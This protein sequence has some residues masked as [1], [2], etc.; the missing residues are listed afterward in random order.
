M[1]IQL[2]T[3]DRA[4]TLNKKV[5]KMERVY[6]EQECRAELKK[7]QT[8]LNI[9]N[10]LLAALEEG[11]CAFID[12]AKG[13]RF[14]IVKAGTPTTVANTGRF[15]SAEE[16]NQKADDAARA[17]YLYEKLLEVIEG[18][19]IVVCDDEANKFRIDKP[20]SVVMN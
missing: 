7:H 12:E 4:R 19:T 13:P 9:W 17:V 15:I 20:T 10:S 16:A 5:M 14:W 18:G 3:A 6:T 8:D 1:D 11:Y 2:R